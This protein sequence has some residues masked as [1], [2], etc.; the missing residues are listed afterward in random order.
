M[1]PPFHGSSVKITSGAA[2]FSPD[3]TSPEIAPV[4]V[5]MPIGAPGLPIG[6][7]G[8]ALPLWKVGFVALPRELKRLASRMSWPS[9]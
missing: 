9:A 6:S 1:N 2:T 3:S 7:F 8:D 5:M 4:G